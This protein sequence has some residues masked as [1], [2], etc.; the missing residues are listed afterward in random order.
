M[1]PPPLKFRDEDFEV[2]ARSQLGSDCALQ[3]SVL[4]GRNEPALHHYHN[5]Y[6]DVLGMP[7]LPLIE[8]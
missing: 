8:P 1:A 3:E 6:R 2:A 4:F 5:T 7:P